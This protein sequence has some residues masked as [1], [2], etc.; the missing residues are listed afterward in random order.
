MSQA[1]DRKSRVSIHAPVR[2]RLFLRSFSK[3]I[4]VSI[5]APVRE[6]LIFAGC[7]DPEKLFQFTLP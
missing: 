3:S 2:E 6:R 1:K 7:D 5:H 4:Y